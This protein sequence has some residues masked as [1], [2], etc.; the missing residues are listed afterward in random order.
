MVLL[1]HSGGIWEKSG[2]NSLIFSRVL[3]A[4]QRRH[5]ARPAC[6]TIAKCRFRHVRVGSAGLPL[7]WLHTLYSWQIFERMAGGDEDCGRHYCDPIHTRYVILLGLLDSNR[8]YLIHLQARTIR[9][10][11]RT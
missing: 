9:W 8:L 4:R 5:G 3:K 11:I 1:A 7:Q 2:L 6:S 10:I